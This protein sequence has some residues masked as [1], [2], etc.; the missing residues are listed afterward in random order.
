[1]DADVKGRAVILA[2]LLV[3]AC[4]AP[5]RVAAS[6]PAG[7]MEEGRAQVDQ[8]TAII[9]RDVQALHGGQV[10]Y[11]AADGSGYCQ[12]VSRLPDVVPL[13][14]KRY[15]L[16]VPGDAMARMRRLAAGHAA[17]PIPSSSAPGLPD[18]SR[19]RIS[20]RLASGRSVD[21][22]RWQHDQN[23]EFDDLYQA[24]LAVVQAVATQ[25]PLSQGKFDPNWVPDGFPG[26]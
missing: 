4:A 3:A 22:S 25:K 11:L 16:A 13:A 10:V 23:V 19:P 18:A 9:L 1:M 2:A 17:Q 5:E 14:E 6:R 20:V 26:R 8:V 15:R 24:L 7:A 12:L 21:V